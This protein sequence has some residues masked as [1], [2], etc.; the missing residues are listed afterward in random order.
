MTPAIALTYPEEF[1]SWL[2]PA[3]LRN[4]LHPGFITVSENGCHLACFTVTCHD[5]NFIL[6]AVKILKNDQA[7]ERSPI[8]LRHIV[9]VRFP[10]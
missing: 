6:L 10:G 1:F 8:H 5:R 7:R 4:R 2:Q 3:E 9:L